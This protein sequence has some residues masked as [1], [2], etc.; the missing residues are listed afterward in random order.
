LTTI[1][2]EACAEI[3]RD[4]G[5]IPAASTELLAPAMNASTLVVVND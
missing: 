5:S 1:H 2:V 3:L 4:A